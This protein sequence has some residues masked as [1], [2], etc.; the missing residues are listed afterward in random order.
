VKKVR[1]IIEK[2]DLYDNR[3]S[4]SERKE[5]KKRFQVIRK[6]DKKIG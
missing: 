3:N 1:M 4:W 2:K 6:D 5:D